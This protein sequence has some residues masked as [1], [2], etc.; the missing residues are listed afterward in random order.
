[1]K[2]N[3]VE[4]CLDTLQ[5]TIEERFDD[6]EALLK[7]SLIGNVM[8]QMDRVERDEDLDEPV[9]IQGQEAVIKRKIQIGDKTAAFL[10]FNDR[11]TLGSIRKINEWYQKSE[12]K[13]IPVFTFE[14]RSTS[15]RE[16][17]RQEKLSY[18]VVNEELYIG[19]VSDRT[20][21]TQLQT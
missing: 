15:Q 4:K 13:I 19:S 10:S 18:Y 1:M 11:I 8:D 5:K 9:N 16:K 12:A 2:E 14:K 7:L 21:R 6:V 17:M 20:P 3:D